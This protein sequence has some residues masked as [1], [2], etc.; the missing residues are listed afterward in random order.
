ME[1]HIVGLPETS[2]LLQKR[3][4]EQPRQSFLLR[5]GILRPPEGNRF[6]EKG[7]GIIGALAG[8]DPRI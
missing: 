7:Y 3:L 8:M 2:D 1:L 5:G 4:F 6:H